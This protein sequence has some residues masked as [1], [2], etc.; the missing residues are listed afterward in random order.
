MTICVAY[1]QNG[2]VYCASDTRI[3]CGDVCGRDKTE[4]I[5]EK[6]GIIYCLAGNLST[7]QALRYE[8]DYEL[9]EHYDNINEVIYGDFR[10]KLKK[11]LKDNPEYLTKKGNFN[12]DLMIVADN[13]IFVVNT[14]FS[15]TEPEFNYYCIGCGSDEG[16]AA[17]Y[18]LNQVKGISTKTKIRI[19]I[20][21]AGEFERGCNKTVKQ[22]N[23]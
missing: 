16:F 8:F 14:D 9:P 17:L 19:A 2:K 18:A 11:F 3:S 10:Q 22:F 21:T 15:I 12:D 4:K 6:G 20:E 7:N 1:K 13:K 5:F 23:Y